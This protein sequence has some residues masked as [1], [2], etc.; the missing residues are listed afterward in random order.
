MPGNDERTDELLQVDG[1][2]PQALSGR[3]LCI[4]PNPSG[5]PRVHSV[6]L[7]AGTAASYRHRWLGTRAPC[8]AATT[9]LIVFAGRILTL[10]NGAIAQELATSLETSPVD[11][12][13]HHLGVGAFP[14]MDP[15]TG[16]LNLISSPGETTALNHVISAGG[17]TRR[18]HPID[19]APAPVLDL[20]ITTRRVVLLADGFTGVTDRNSERP[21]AWLPSKPTR[22]GRI[23]DAYDDDGGGVVM[24][25]VG[26]GLERWTM[27]A[28]ANAACRRVLDVAPQHLARF[29]EQST[30]SPRRYLYCVGGDRA[31]TSGGTTVFKHDLVAGTRED[32]MFGDGRQAGDFAFI[33]DPERDVDEDGGWLLGLVHDQAAE[34]TSLLVLDA[35]DV[36]GPLVARIHLPRRIPHSRSGLWVPSPK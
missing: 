29:N 22:A 2:L 33:V 19:D 20:A 21:I 36:A 34:R 3:Y 27:T 1:S 32:R 14:K 8:G 9:N 15:C 5:G 10:A 17:M 26:E 12:A 24:H 23:V 31:V 7:R 16:E 11:L 18:T 30:G 4:E 6:A 25:L 13:G 28:S 35:A